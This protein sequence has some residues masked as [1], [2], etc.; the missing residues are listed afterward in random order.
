VLVHYLTR[1]SFCNHWA[2]LRDLSTAGAGLM[3]GWAPEPGAIVLL[4]LAPPCSW[5]TFARLACIVRAEKRLGSYVVGCRFRT[6][7]SEEELAGVLQQ[8]GPPPAR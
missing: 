6:S 7:L 1:P 8:F 2:G 3:L 4:G 5:V